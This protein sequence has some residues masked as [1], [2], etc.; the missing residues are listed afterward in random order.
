M[1][2]II[3]NKKSNSI[4]CFTFSALLLLFTFHF[5]AAAQDIVTDGELYSVRVQS[6][7]EK[8][9]SKYERN[10][11]ESAYSM[12]ELGQEIKNNLSNREQS[13]SI[14]YIND[15]GSLKEE[16]KGVFDGI[17]SQDDYLHYTIERYSYVYEGFEG[18][19]TISFK[20]QYTETK[21]QFDYVTSRVDEILSQI[22]TDGMDDYQKE[23]AIHDYI[24]LN[25]EY[26][27]SYTENS[28]YAALTKGKTV[29]QGYSLL[30]YKMLNKAGIETRIVEGD[31]KGLHLWNLVRLDGI[32]YHLDCTWDD[33]VPNRDGF[34]SYRFFNLTDEQ[35]SVDHK[36]VKS[37]HQAS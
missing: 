37:P 23:K 24:V 29:C 28:A 14:R 9:K 25:V 36:M 21:E 33:P 10:I 16:I 27:T 34:V 20:V 15:T 11:Y 12:E 13:F 22:I 6:N 5:A 31:A 3:I 30:A 7:L 35:I 26:D 8:N 1:K 18:D 17:M 2:V 4:L 19:V 32:W